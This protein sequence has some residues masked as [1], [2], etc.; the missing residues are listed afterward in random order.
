[1]WLKSAE[2]I[3][4]IPLLDFLLMPQNMVLVTPFTPGEGLGC[5][6]RLPVL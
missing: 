3:E 2:Q 4:T 1:M 5:T 6:E